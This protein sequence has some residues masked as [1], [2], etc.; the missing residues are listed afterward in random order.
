MKM[1][2]FDIDTH[3]EAEVWYSDENKIILRIFFPT[4]HHQFE[5]IEL[6][7]LPQCDC[8]I[9]ENMSTFIK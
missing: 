6:Y 3:Y 7:H 8:Y 4:G 1:I 5:I 9:G 2:T